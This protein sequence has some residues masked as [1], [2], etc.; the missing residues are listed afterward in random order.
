MEKIYNSIFQYFFHN[1]VGDFPARAAEPTVAV[2]AAPVVSTAAVRVG[3]HGWSVV[4]RL[5]AAVDAQRRVCATSG[6]GGAAVSGTGAPL[7]RCST[8]LGGGLPRF[9]VSVAQTGPSISIQ[10]L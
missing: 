9:P 4:R 1:S 7:A 3:Q 5:R 2:C 8:D 10:V 6:I